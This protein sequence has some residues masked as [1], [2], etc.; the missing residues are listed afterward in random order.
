MIH[1]SL[2]SD[3]ALRAMSLGIPLINHHISFLHTNNSKHR[4]GMAKAM[5]MGDNA[6]GIEPLKHQLSQCIHMPYA[7]L[8]PT[9]SHN[10]GYMRPTLNLHI[11]MKYPTLLP[12]H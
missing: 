10:V 9:S 3:I 8:L 2:P 1:K 7:T 6:E 5:P 4:G 11:P 12:T